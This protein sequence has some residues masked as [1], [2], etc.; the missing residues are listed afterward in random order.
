M[1]STC[2]DR[3]ALADLSGKLPCFTKAV[4]R[5]LCIWLH[6][7]GTIRRASRSERF[8]Q[9][10]QLWGGMRNVKRAILREEQGPTPDLDPS[11]AIRCSGY[12]FVIDLVRLRRE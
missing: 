3:D 11:S 6:G 7:P 8:S 12:L 10:P 9:A 2:R 4:S 1:L 5:G